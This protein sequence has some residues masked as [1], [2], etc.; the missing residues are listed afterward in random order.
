[1]SSVHLLFND[2]PPCFNVLLLRSTS[3]GEL[4]SS[5]YN[6]GTVGQLVTLWTLANCSSR[7]ILQHEFPDSP[8]VFIDTCLG[9]SGH[10]LF[11]AYKLLDEARRDYQT[12]VKY[13]KLKS[14]RKST[15]DFRPEN[16]EILI[17]DLD[18]DFERA[19][20][21]R[22]LQ[23]ARRAKVKA[24]AKLRAELAAQ[25]EEEENEKKAQAEGT[26]QE[27]G[28]CFGDYPRN[29]MIHC[30]SDSIHWFCRG[31]ALRNAE[32]EVGQSKYELT[33]MSMDGC[34]ARFSLSQR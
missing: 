30:D 27:C 20:I 18:G 7:N 2:D 8:M 24:E 15:T 11:S 5:S 32:T 22:E 1:M 4:S 23:A 13:T 21:L 26:M 3:L 16:I 28:C 25:L 9:Q 19:E 33:C 14:A 34:S 31:C 12:G 10:R 6:S 29:R 17:N